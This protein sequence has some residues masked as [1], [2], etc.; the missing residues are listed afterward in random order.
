MSFDQIEFVTKGAQV[1]IWLNACLELLSVWLGI[2]GSIVV[3]WYLNIALHIELE[4]NIET[5][6][7]IY[8]AHSSAL[9]EKSIFFKLK[10]SLAYANFVL[11]LTN[12]NDF[13]REH[14]EAQLETRCKNVD[15]E[16]AKGDDPAPAS[17]GV[18]MLTKRGRL[19]V[20]AKG[21]KRNVYEWNK[22]ENI[23]ILHAETC[24]SLT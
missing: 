10:I 15:Q 18:I 6:S 24:L 13:E 7:W 23:Q 9:G 12:S 14:R 11:D 5:H 1:E 4:K 22:A 2:K 16:A 21:C 8:S 19:P 20:H 3:W 17:F